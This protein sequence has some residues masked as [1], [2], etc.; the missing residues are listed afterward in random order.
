MPN[1]AE[2]PA[3]GDPVAHHGVVVDPPA[4]LGEPFTVRVPDFDEL[5]VFEIR[6]WQ[7]R[8]VTVPA[9]GDEVLVVID[10][11]A[12]PWVAAWWPAAG[13]TPIEGGEGGGSSVDAF[14]LGG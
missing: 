12:E 11:V 1:L 14:F 4:A 6:R 3:P 8:A 2:P 5:H 10:D 13:D 7:S 9:A